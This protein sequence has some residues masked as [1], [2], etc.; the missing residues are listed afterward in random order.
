[1]R[2]EDA[3]APGLGVWIAAATIAA[4]AVVVLMV[5]EAFA[6][7]PL[8]SDGTPSRITAS[9]SLADT[10]MRPAPAAAR[11]QDG[12]P[13]ARVLLIGT[14]LAQAGL[15]KPDPDSSKKTHVETSYVPFESHVPG[16]LLQREFILDRFEGQFLTER[17]TRGEFRPQLVLLQT[18]LFERQPIGRV[19]EMKERL[20]NRRF[21]VREWIDS[22]LPEP[23]R[24]GYL[25]DFSAEA[26]G[27]R[28][29]AAHAE[30]LEDEYELN[31]DYL[32]SMKPQ[33]EACVAAGIPVWLLDLGRSRRIEHEMQA[34][35]DEW[36][37]RLR[38]LV[39]IDGVHY[40]RFE[41]LP[42]EFYHDDSHLN[43][44][45]ARRFHQ[46]IEPI[47]REAVADVRMRIGGRDA[48]PSAV[49]ARGATGVV[50]TAGGARP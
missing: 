44:A 26:H 22:F 11:A 50:G 24:F 30:W 49:Q 5:A 21:A 39:A 32:A 16:L 19:A 12:G 23:M 17:C 45:G 34:T 40:L 3:Q 15:L 37:R 35:L 2:H 41:A 7:R 46:W 8:R 28:T 27:G 48:A 43:D 1:M 31:F 4:I 47:L 9:E 20:R 33:I 29:V 25:E 10:V 42:H 38:E 36:R 18:D 14:S 13:E 6:Y